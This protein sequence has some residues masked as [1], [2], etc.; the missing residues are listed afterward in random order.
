MALIDGDLNAQYKALW[1]YCN[2]IRRTNP[3]TS[4]Y[5]K[6]VENDVPDKP[7]R[8]QRIYICF[9]GCKEG[10]KSGC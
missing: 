8:F 3:N 7:K 4:V 5:M 10:F 6:L 9:S 1:N 2:E